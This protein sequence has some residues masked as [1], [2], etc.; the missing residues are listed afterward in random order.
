[1]FVKANYWRT[2]PPCW[3]LTDE[4]AAEADNVSENGRRR[5]EDGRWDS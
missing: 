1:V 5:I 4:R 2:V 3:I